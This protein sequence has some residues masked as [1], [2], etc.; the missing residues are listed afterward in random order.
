MRFTTIGWV[1]V[2]AY[3]GRKWTST[4]TRHVF[5]PFRV[6]FGRDRKLIP[7]R[8]GEFCKNRYS[9]SHTFLNGFDEILTIFRTLAL[10]LGKFGAGDVHKNVLSDCVVRESWLSESRTLLGGVN[11]FVSSP[12]CFV[13]YRLNR[14]ERAA[15]KTVQYF[16]F[17]ENRRRVDRTFLMW[18]ELTFTRV[19]DRMALWK[20][21]MPW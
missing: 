18:K 5:W 8:N 6:K 9:D 15:H 17:R 13:Q 14:R 3:L 11:E 10:D 2:V 21:R 7:L 1:T 4:H 12:Q 16:G 20:Q 19:P